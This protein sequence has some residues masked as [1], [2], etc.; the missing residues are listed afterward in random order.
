M[1]A[2]TNVTP[3]CFQSFH[4]HVSFLTQQTLQKCKTGCEMNPN[5]LWHQPPQ[6]NF[7]AA[8]SQQQQLLCSGTCWR[9]CH[10]KSEH[11]SVSYLAAS[12][13]YIAG[14]SSF[15]WMVWMFLD[16]GPMSTSDRVSVS[17]LYFDICCPA[18]NPA[19]KHCHLVFYRS[20]V[21]SFHTAHLLWKSHLTVLQTHSL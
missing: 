16:R 8:E 3:V 15:V 21:K 17:K 5:Q 12:C 19:V 10:P 9:P 18:L 13:L 2:L 11:V 6:G 1:P 14:D 20:Q 4:C 7:R